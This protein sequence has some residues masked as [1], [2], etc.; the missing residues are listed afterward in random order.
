MWYMLFNNDG[1]LVTSK[2]CTY[3]SAVGSTETVVYYLN[4][5]HSL[6]VYAQRV[7]FILFLIYRKYVLYTIITI[8]NKY[9]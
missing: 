2:L 9:L 3:Y 4:K 1:L 6:F 7:F 5:T 8:N